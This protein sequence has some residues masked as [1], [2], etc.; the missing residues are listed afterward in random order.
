MGSRADIVR[1]LYALTEAGEI[2]EVVDQYDDDAV[3]EVAFQQPPLRGRDGV[4]SYLTRVAS[5]PE[6]SSELSALRFEEHGDAVLVT[7]R[8]RLRD[9][10]K[11]SVVD[12]PGAWVFRF[13]GDKVVEVRAFHDNAAARAALD[14]EDR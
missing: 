2:D 3:V 4:R 5:S 7:G 8:L 10:A 6:I 1:R 13:R 9:E 14:R 12:S 11:R